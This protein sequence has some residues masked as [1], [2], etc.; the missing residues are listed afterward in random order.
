MCVCV[1][2]DLILCMLLNL[3]ISISV[4]LLLWAGGYDPEASEELLQDFFQK[5]LKICVE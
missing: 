3:P 1:L 2:F 5:Y 4:L